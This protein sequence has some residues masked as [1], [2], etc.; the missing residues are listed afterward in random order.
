MCIRDRSLATIS[1]GT[2]GSSIP[3]E[4][5]DKIVHFL[6]SFLFVLLWNLAQNNIATIKIISI[7]IVAIFYG[8]IIETLQ[9]FTAIRTADFFDFLANTLGAVLGT[10]ICLNMP[11]KCKAN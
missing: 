5:K 11:K 3:I 7:L 6:F 10:L 4:N 8:A 1:I 2:I 9:S